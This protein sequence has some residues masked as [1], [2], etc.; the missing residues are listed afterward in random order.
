[1]KSGRSEVI[2]IH[3]TIRIQHPLETSFLVNTR[4][5][6]SCFWPLAL[7]LEVAEEI[8]RHISMCLW[9]LSSYVPCNSAFDVAA[10]PEKDNAWKTRWRHMRKPHGRLF[11][12]SNF[13]TKNLR[14]LCLFGILKFWHFPGPLCLFEIELLN[15]RTF[16]NIMSY[17]QSNLR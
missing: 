13:E 3:R 4:M 5:C 1:M 15:R 14:P 9:F 6:E 10:F 17:R 8:V 11:M 7:L 16:L 12:F 2:K